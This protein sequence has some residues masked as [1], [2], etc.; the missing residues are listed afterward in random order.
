MILR[1]GSAGVALAALSLLVVVAA[2]AYSTTVA[3]LAFEDLVDDAARV[4]HGTCTDVRVERGATGRLQTRVTFSNRRALKGADDAQVEMVLPGGARDGQVL[5]IH[6]MP[7][8]RPGEEV[9]LFATAP[10]ARSGL[11]V[12]VGLA[13]G[14]YRVERTPSGEAIASRDTRGLHLVDLT[15]GRAQPVPGRREAIPLS[16]LLA[17]VEAR[18]AALRPQRR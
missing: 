11:S 18:V 15:G 3:A 16:D 8:F 7:R 6:G 13:Q 14:V 12:P 1:P 4:F 9:V 10:H 5:L 17:Q 2:P